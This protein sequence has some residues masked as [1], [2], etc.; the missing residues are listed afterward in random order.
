MDLLIDSCYNPAL[1]QLYFQTHWLLKPFVY[2]KM[3]AS[4]V[5]RCG[6]CRI[7][8]LNELIPFSRSRKVY[9]NCG[10]QFVYV[11]PNITGICFFTVMDE[12]LRNSGSFTDSDEISFD[13]EVDSVNVVNE[14]EFKDNQTAEFVVSYKMCS[15][16]VNACVFVSVQ[17]GENVWGVIDIGSAEC[18]QTSENRHCGAK[19]EWSTL[20]P[21]VAFLPQGKACSLLSPDPGSVVVWNISSGV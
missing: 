2:R 20:V 7:L 14:D 17:L 5:L 11:R 8:I 9:I 4:A 19:L 1:L 16:V 18:I 12:G 13:G 6:L 10:I 15:C 21:M 3:Y